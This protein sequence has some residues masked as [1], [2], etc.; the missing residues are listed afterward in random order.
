[1]LDLLL[2]NAVVHTVCPDRPPAHSVG[3]WR[4]RIVG[5]DGDIDDLPARRRVDL[6]GATV[7][8]GFHDAHCHTTSVGI[9]ELHLDLG[10]C[11]STDAVLERV[12]VYADGLPDD[13]WVIGFGYLDRSRPDRF[14]TAA[15][16]DRAGSGRPVW[17]TH[18]SGH[19]CAVSSAV[20]RELADPLPGDA[21]RFVHR[22]GTG[23]PTGLLEETAM[24][25]VKDLVG[26][27]SQEQLADA[28]D[29]ATRRY[30]AEGITSFTEAGIGCPGIDHGPAEIG[31][32]QRARTT[33]RLH[34]RAQLMVYSELLHE[35]AGSRGET[36]ASGLDL[37]ARTGLGDPWLRL[38]AMKIWIDGAGTAGTAAVTGPAGEPPAR[39]SFADDPVRMRRQIA[40]AHRSGWQVAGHA[41]GDAA[42][43]LLLD[44]LASAGP[45]DELRARRH[46]VEHAGLVR[47]DQVQRMADLGVLAVIQP[48]FIPLFGDLLADGFG[49]ARV[50]WSIRAASF[51]AAGVPVAASS[52]R[53]VAPATPLAALQALVE[54][55]TGTGACYGPQ[56]RIPV[57]AALHSYTAGAAFAAGAESEIGSLAEGR[58][59]DLVVLGCDPLS[60]EPA[61]LG[62]IPVLATMVDG[63]AVHD[64]EDRLS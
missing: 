44:A 29:R 55:R 35:V 28:V 2:H 60:V 1:M 25:A 8:P 26:P 20:L 43:D 6:A 57:A 30:V 49:A 13:A 64:P 27:A 23:R 48:L 41:M 39:Q 56:E 11:A 3:I 32:Y 50:P 40:D 45:V 16:L 62:E 12:A 63:R 33:G 5:L 14:P 38:G 36:P 18:R 4:G 53:P 37:G 61:A 24:D 15:E 58:L 31:A 59:A 46:R 17:L 47:P 22:D 34:A 7:V 19:S 21:A 42:V 9:E 52:D 10:G 51:L 54:R